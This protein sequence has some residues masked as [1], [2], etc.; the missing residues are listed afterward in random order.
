MSA[1]LGFITAVA[2]YGLNS[3]LVRPKRG[4]GPF[5]MQVVVEETHHD[6]LEITEHPVELGLSGN[7]VTDHAYKRPEEVIIRGGWSDSPSYNSL[8]AAGLNAA[9]STIN[10]VQSLVTGNDIA[11]VKDVYKR[12]IAFQ[13][14]RELMDVYT[15]KRTYKNMLIK[16]VTMVTDA[17]HENSLFLTVTMR[18]LII[19]TTQTI[20][21]PIPVGSVQLLPGS[22]NPPS[23]MGL[24]TPV[25]STKFNGTLLGP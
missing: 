2:Q 17:D 3:I 11:G 10:G 14:K 22:T 16:A 4:I 12:F 18:Q 9:A 23:N 6:E 7:I 20:A 15:G 8:L 25:P 24:K 19:V 1:A 13:A 5:T 21:A